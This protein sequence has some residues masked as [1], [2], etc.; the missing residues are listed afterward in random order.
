RD[1]VVHLANEIMF[2]DRILRRFVQFSA[3]HHADTDMSLSEL[4]ISHLL[5]GKFLVNRFLRVSLEF[6]ARYVCSR[7]H[8]AGRLWVRRIDFPL[9]HQHSSR[10]GRCRKSQQKL[11]HMNLAV[12]SIESLLGPSLRYKF[13]TSKY[14]APKGQL[15]SRCS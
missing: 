10:T 8:V 2:R 15:T 7:T 11:F 3:M 9:C 1:D 6:S 14:A 4:D 13:E 12:K 5:I